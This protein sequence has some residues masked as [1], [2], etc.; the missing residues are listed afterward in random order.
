MLRNNYSDFYGE[1]GAF[2]KRK[3]NFLT[4]VNMETNFRL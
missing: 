3:Y 1:C 4:T 2:R